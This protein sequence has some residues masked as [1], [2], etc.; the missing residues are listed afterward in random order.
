MDINIPGGFTTLSFYKFTYK[1][2]VTETIVFPFLFKGLLFRNSIK[3]VFTK[4]FEPSIVNEIF[5]TR[6]SK[7]TAEKLKIG[8]SPP[9]GYLLEDETAPKLK[10]LPGDSIY[11]NLILIGDS[12]RY[13]NMFTDAILL[14]GK[15]YWLGR[16]SGFGNGRFELESVLLKG[17]NIYDNEKE[18]III[19]NYPACNIDD[20]YP[21]RNYKRL[22]LNFITPTCIVPEYDVKPV[23]I[24]RTTDIKLFIT[25][26]YRRLHHLQYLY[27]GNRDFT[28][29]KL[30]YASIKITTSDLKNKIFI[31]GR[32]KFEGFTGSITIEGISGELLPLFFLGEQLH[33]GKDCSYGFGKFEILN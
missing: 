32:E 6:I 18:K 7:E 20:F 33:I 5:E 16:K 13:L 30:N 10:Y 29:E 15:K 12:I 23:L 14:L 28:F 25:M 26:L 21:K 1:L 4:E 27:C 8:S 19:N 11:V 22:L 31:I 9:R 17:E 24:N 3:N 2:K